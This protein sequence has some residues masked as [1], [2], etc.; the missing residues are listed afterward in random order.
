[1]CHPLT[2]VVLNLSGI[3]DVETRKLT[4]YRKRPFS[5]DIL[6]TKVTHFKLV[7]FL[8]HQLNNTKHISIKKNDFI[9]PNIT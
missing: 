3:Y 7:P 8:L 2:L 5:R 1:M 6:K 4:K 9:I